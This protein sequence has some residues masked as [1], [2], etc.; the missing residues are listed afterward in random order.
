MWCFTNMSLKIYEK[1]AARD[2]P[3]ISSATREFAGRLGIEKPLALAIEMAH[4][5]FVRIESMRAYV[6]RDPDDGE[7]YIVLEV[8]S[9]GDPGDDTRSYGNYLDEWSASVDWPASQMIR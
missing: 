1:V 2:N 3:E 7:E 9:H 8:N 5:Y 4:R 6:D